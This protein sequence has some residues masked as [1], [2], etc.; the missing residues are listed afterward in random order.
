MDIM[1]KTLLVLAI[2]L[3]FPT[4]QVHA[5]DLGNLIGHLQST[6]QNIDNWQAHFSQ[7]TFVELLNKT[8]SKKG[9][10]SIKKPGKLRIEYLGQNSK[11]YVSNGKS[12]WIYTAGDS[13]VEVYKKISKILAKEALSFLQ[14]LGEVEKEFH[15]ELYHLKKNDESMMKK[16]N[17]YFLELTPLEVG[18]VIEKIVIGMDKKSYT[19]VETTLFNTSG[20]RTHYVFNNIQFNTTLPDHLFEF[21]KPKGVR[22]M[23]GT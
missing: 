22:V 18:S 20:N 23:R 19:V 10:I 11:L 13:Q 21:K 17:L 3:F 1:N 8:I 6:Y 4:P 2:F 12:L 15:V 9:H 16:K 14:G 5:D 7:A